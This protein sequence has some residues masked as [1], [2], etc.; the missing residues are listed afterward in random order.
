MS[1]TRRDRRQAA[2]HPTDTAAP[3][4][5]G[6]TGATG[7]PA[8]APTP[9]PTPAHPKL[10]NFKQD[11]INIVHSLLSVF[12]GKSVEGNNQAII[13]KATQIATAINAVKA[14]PEILDTAKTFLQGLLNG[15]HA[16]NLTDDE[17][18]DLV[19][20]AVDLA[21]AYHNQV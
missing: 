3:G 7:A 8:P 15:Q 9:T 11:V 17:I 18:K 12:H 2:H 6:N 1:T 14:D 5:T 16:L 19:T 4:P 21:T 20:K 10:N 13:D